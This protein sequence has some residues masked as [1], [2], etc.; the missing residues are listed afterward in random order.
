MRRPLSLLLSPSID[1]EFDYMTTTKA[2]ATNAI[3][4]TTNCPCYDFNKSRW[5]RPSCLSDGKRS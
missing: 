5:T 4:T 1:S 3:S 2:T